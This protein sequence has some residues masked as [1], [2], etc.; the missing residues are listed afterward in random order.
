MPTLLT[1]FKPHIHLQGLPRITTQLPAKILLLSQSWSVEVQDRGQ[2]VC[3]LLRP[4]PWAC[5]QPPSHCFITW[6]SLVLGVICVLLSLHRKYRLDPLTFL[7]CLPHIYKDPVS[8]CSPMLSVLT[9]FLSL[10]TQ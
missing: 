8:K 5:R 1:F 10:R 7:F 6:L 3:F 2:L 4:P 9:S